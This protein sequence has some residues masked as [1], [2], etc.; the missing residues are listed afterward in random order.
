M[1]ENYKHLY[2]QMKK[3]VAMYQDEIVPGMRKTIEELESSREELRENFVDYVCS[4]IPNP[5]P[6]CANQCRECVDRHG[7]CKE[8][9]ETCKG[10][11]PLGERREG[12]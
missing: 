7:W 5:A 9:P 1:A 3:M 11:K 8:D 6:Y 10:F 12:E 2:E 4:G